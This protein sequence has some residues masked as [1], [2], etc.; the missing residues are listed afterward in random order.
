MNDI[1]TVWPIY[2]TYYV[3]IGHGRKCMTFR[4]KLSKKYIKWLTVKYMNSDGRRG[5][6]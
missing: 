1:F 2:T 6:R 3:K 5:G 4:K